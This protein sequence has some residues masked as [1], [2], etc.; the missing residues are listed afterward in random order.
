ME[1]SE[2]LKQFHQEIYADITADDQNGRGG[3]SSG[4]AFF[5]EVKEW[6]DDNEIIS[7]PPDYVS[8]NDRSGRPILSGC[9]FDTDLIA[10]DSVSNTSLSLFLSY[11]SQ[12]SDVPIWN[13]VDVD[14]CIKGLKDFF[15]NCY[16]DKFVKVLAETEPVMQLV[17]DIHENQDKIVTVHLYIITDAVLNIRKEV[18]AFHENGVNFVV[19]VFDLKFLYELD[20]NSRTED[21]VYDFRDTEF[22][23][24]VGCNGIKCLDAS[25]SDANYRA[26]LA[27]IPGYT[28]AKLYQMHGPRMLESNV[29]AFLQNKCKVNRG[30]RNTIKL[31]P[32]KFFAYNNGISAIAEEVV[33]ENSRIV[34]MKN[35]Q[36]VNG[37]QTTASI[38]SAF[39]KDKIEEEKLNKIQV[40]VKISEMPKDNPENGSMV[41]NI[42]KY[43]NSQ[44]KIND[45]DFFSTHPF[46]IRFE[47]LC[48]D[49]RVPETAKN[50]GTGWF[51]ERARGSYATHLA[52]KKKASEQLEF[53]TKFPKNQCIKTTELA[54]SLAVWDSVPDIVSKGA[55]YVTQ[56][57]VDKVE[58]LWGDADS[59]SNDN[60]DFNA[61]YLKEA[62][63]KVIVFK[64]CDSLVSK[65][66]WY[67]NSFKANIVAYTISYIADK[68]KEIGKEV[69]YLDIWNKQEISSAFKQ[70]LNDL[71]CRVLENIISLAGKGNVT[72]YCKKKDCW[73]KIKQISFSF[74]EAFMR[75]LNELGASEN[76]IKMARKKQSSDNKLLDEIRL[77]RL[78][79]QQ[80]RQIQQDAKEERFCIS[81]SENKALQRIIY[82]RVPNQ[83]QWKAI[84]DLLIRMKKNGIPIPDL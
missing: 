65:A 48:K 49:A 26:Y 66:S 8:Y 40:Q 60:P 80:C 32:E 16:T 15:F 24:E 61:A 75:E 44:N 2:E 34:G 39:V 37:G 11:Y 35:F 50:R 83:L 76:L 53:K 4:Q 64:E 73:D 36:I 71:G 72:Q 68:L 25:S 41:A 45:S 67:E 77:S 17:R 6:L 52:F 3:I 23:R 30:I 81:Y 78:T 7:D 22:C 38:Y 1:I 33:V 82:G 47:Q 42:A 18:S 54:K 10:D 43:A 74:P 9:S 62:I 12:Q 70:V 19:H 5:D 56:Y 27:V 63:A 46:N 28:L 79:P 58:Q 21:L 57:F 31:E 69:N 84:K 14:R 20:N 29:R 51:Y 55:Q 59:L 13:K